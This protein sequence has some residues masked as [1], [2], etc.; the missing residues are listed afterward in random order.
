MLKRLILPAALLL[1]CTPAAFAQQQAK[2]PATTAAQPAQQKLTPEQQQA[3]MKFRQTM[4]ANAESIAKL[5]DQGKA[6]DVYDQTSTVAKQ[7]ISRND[8][9]SGVTKQ[10][11]NVGKLES[12]KLAAVTHSVS[13]GEN[14]LPAGDYINVVFASKFSS[15]K[16]PI[17][18]LVSYH[19]DSDKVWRVSGYTLQQPTP[20]KR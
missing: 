12:R 17:R 1:A 16:A 18:E 14:K 20:A 2:A 4:A 11:D 7:S 8:F 6:G 5:I 9:V 15:E 13:K 3:I 19:Y 10:R